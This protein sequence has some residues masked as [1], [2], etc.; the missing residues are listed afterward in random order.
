VPS[1]GSWIEENAML[2]AVVWPIVITVVFLP[3]AVRKF[4]RLGR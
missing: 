4:Q 3:L 2:M 1:G